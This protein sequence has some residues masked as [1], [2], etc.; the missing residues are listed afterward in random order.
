ME[1]KGTP[2]LENVRRG[3]LFLSEREPE[4][5][6]RLDGDNDAEAIAGEIARRAEVLLSP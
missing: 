5:I 1:E 4:R 2:F 6:T 3:F